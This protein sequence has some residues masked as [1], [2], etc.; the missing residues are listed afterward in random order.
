MSGPGAAWGQEMREGAE[1][2]VDY[3][4][5]TENGLS[6]RRLKLVVE[7]DAGDAKQAV[8]IANRLMSST[9]PVDFVVG[10]ANS[11]TTLPAS[12]IYREGGAFLFSAVN[13]ENLTA[14]GWSQVFRL[15]PPNKTYEIHVADEIIESGRSNIAII[16]N[17]TDYARGFSDGLK[18]TLSRRGVTEQMYESIPIGEKDFSALISKLK[19]FEIDLVV[20]ALY[21]QEAGLLTRQSVDLGFAAKGSGPLFYG[22]S[23][24]ASLDFYRAS[25]GAAEGARI[26][27]ASGCDIGLLREELASDR[28]GG[29]FIKLLRER[30]MELAVTHTIIASA[31]QIIAQAIALTGGVDKRKLSDVLHQREFSTVRGLLSFGPSGELSQPDRSLALYE[32]RSSGPHQIK[33]YG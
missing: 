2:A 17:G 5:G 6:G 30:N 29:G 25:G 18:E 22:H 31:F 10:H 19:K 12:Q 27:S 23:L 26:V 15:I 21:P 33:R 4:N 8:S 11:A 24:L 32:I 16:H 3:I 13:A 28:I 14:S 7:D 9:P 20:L 1:V